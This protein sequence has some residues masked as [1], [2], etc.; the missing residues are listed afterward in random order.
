MAKI[1]YPLLL[2]AGFGFTVVLAIH[3]ATLFGATYLFTHSLRFVGP[4]LFVVWLPTVLIS[5]R[6][7]RD[8]KQ[9]DFWRAALRGCP[10]WARRAQWVLF[11]YAWVGFF[12]LPFLYG[13]GMEL[14]ANKARS[15]SAVLLAFYST[16][17]AVLYS[18]IHVE[19]LDANRRC[20][21]G[22]RVP[23]LAKY[24]EE[25]GA[26]VQVTPPASPSLS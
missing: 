8:T 3:V 12:A 11:G 7:T 9:K 18:A 2:L 16:A 14:P 22:H 17:F 1:A 19:K 10:E 15:M 21:N 4:G 25:C 6:L 20:S 24:C 5:S 23:P 26:P 13:G